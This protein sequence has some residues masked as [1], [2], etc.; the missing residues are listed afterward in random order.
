MHVITTLR[1][2][3]ET[4]RV[5]CNEFEKTVDKGKELHDKATKLLGKERTEVKN[6]RDQLKQKQEELEFQ[7][8]KTDD[9]EKLAISLQ[10]Q[11]EEA[12]RQKEVA[13]HE[14]EGRLQGSVKEVESLTQE[15]ENLNNERLA[16]KKAESRVVNMSEEKRR[17]EKETN[18]LHR[19]LEEEQTKTAEKETLAQ[20]LTSQLRLGEEK[21]LVS[22]EELR[23]ME[24]E[25]HKCREK[26]TTLEQGSYSKRKLE[27]SKAVLETK[28]QEKESKEQAQE[29]D[30]E[31]TKK[32]ALNIR[33]YEEIRDR[34]RRYRIE[35]NEARDELVKLGNLSKRPSSPMP[36]RKGA[37]LME[38][39]KKQALNAYAYQEIRDRCR[40]YRIERN[41]ARDELVKLG[42]LSKRP[43]SPM[44]TRKGAGLMDTNHK[45]QQ[46]LEGSSARHVQVTRATDSE[47]RD[48][49]HPTVLPTQYANYRSVVP[50]TSSGNANHVDGCSSRKHPNATTSLP[51]NQP[52]VLSV[53]TLTPVSQLSHCNN[54]H[55]ITINSTVFLL[56]QFGQPE[57]GEVAYL[58][59][60]CGDVF[61]QEYVGVVFDLPGKV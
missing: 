16:L 58:G 43:S 22:D 48:M 6:H 8:K 31:T 35:R 56:N 53:S 7:A 2:E 54:K 19:R 51:V 29:N 61:P 44:P 60:T 15:I 46:K 20:Q 1:L 21:V 14:M 36:T 25:L 10:T 40:R 9:A 3:K 45:S 50:V 24:T 49:R 38:T 30:F 12:K 37:G 52:G 4:L 41:E 59:K 32:Q 28:L 34:C 17:L 23:K 57:F 18:Q 39:T 5:K 42:K 33:A 55:D 13:L 11:L 47:D 26:L 27:T